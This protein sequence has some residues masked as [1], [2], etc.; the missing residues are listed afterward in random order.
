MQTPRNPGGFPAWVK[1]NCLQ[2][3]NDNSHKKDS[4]ADSHQRKIA[5]FVVRQSSKKAWQ[6]EHKC[7]VR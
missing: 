5:M 3:Q 1:K 7:N 4:N 2:F 6:T